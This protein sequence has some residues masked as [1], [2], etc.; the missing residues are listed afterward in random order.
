MRLKDKLKAQALAD[1]QAGEIFRC[2]IPFC[3][4]LSMRSAGAGFGLLNCKYHQA[5]LERY[6]HPVIPSLTGAE[7]RPYVESAKRWLHSQK[8][9]AGG[10]LRLQHALQAVAAL[11]STAGYAPPAMDIKR[12]SAEDKA[13]AAFARM[14]ERDNEKGWTAVTPERLMAAHMGV[15]AILADD[16]WAP[17][18]EDYRLVQTG[19]AAH[20]LA[21]GT[22]REWGSVYPR[23]QG[24]VLRI[25]GRAI[26]EA[27]GAIAQEQSQA[28]I[29]AKEARFGRHPC[30]TPGYEPEWR[31]KDRAKHAEAR[32]KREQ[33][34]HLQR[35]GEAIRRL[36]R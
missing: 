1:R 36:L 33:Q 7:I 28:I 29:A 19:K 15:T 13:R 35:Q 16:T 11:M 26:D 5:R 34:Q 14:R 24:Q 2:P 20:R 25:I 10:N 27:C 30:H 8:A 6:G 3:G 9:S 12:W 21:S 23:S 4:R 22:H 32:K 17:S 31:K 18:S